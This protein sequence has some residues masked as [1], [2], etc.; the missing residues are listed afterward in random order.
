MVDVSFPEPFR[1]LQA[2]AGWALPTETARNRKRL[3]STM[4]EM[5]ALRDAL[6]PQF[7][8][9]MDYLNR[10]PLDAMPEESRNLLYLTLSL[11]EV[12]PAIELYK[13]PTVIDGFD[14]RRFIAEE[15]FRMRPRP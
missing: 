7:D 15:E 1:G 11:A 9:V 2:F 12:A 5:G 4:D 13:Q 6:L 3:A 10:F 8:A 14:S